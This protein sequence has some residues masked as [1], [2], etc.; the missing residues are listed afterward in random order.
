MCLHACVSVCA[1][2][3]CVA[4]C[5]CISVCASVCVPKHVYVQYLC[6]CVSGVCV[7]ACT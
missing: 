7:H 5:M 2:V 3:V 4:V 6:A 1:C